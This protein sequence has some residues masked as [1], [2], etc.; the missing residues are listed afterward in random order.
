MTPAEGRRRRLLALHNAELAGRAA[1]EAG[2]PEADNPYRNKKLR[3]AVA[4]LF[5]AWATGHK[6]R[7]R[8]LKFTSS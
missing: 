6:E 1:A 7:L 5:W 8:E 3:G 2:K 4:G